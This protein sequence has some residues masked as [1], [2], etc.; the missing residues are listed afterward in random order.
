MDYFGLSDRKVTVEECGEL[1][2]PSTGV[3]RVRHQFRTQLKT[4]TSPCAMLRAMLN[5]SVVRGNACEMSVVVVH[6]L[7]CFNVFCIFN[8]D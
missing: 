1:Q 2:Q 3:G 6:Y 4:K 7:Y 5:K 8:W